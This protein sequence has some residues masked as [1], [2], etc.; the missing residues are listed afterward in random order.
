[1]SNT[2]LGSLGLI[3]DMRTR[4]KCEFIDG[5]IGTDQVSKDG[6]EIEPRSH[7]KD[8]VMD[9]KVGFPTLT[10]LIHILIHCNIYHYYD[11]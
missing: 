11:V 2:L 4:L 5:E 8:S 1:V 7:R 6:I 10:I 9:K 3:W